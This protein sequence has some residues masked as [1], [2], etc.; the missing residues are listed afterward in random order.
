MSK[1]FQHKF[2]LSRMSIIY[3]MNGMINISE[4]FKDRM[5]YYIEDIV[6]D[7]KSP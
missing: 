1:L 7:L 5:V 4:K 3:I 6:Y 2:G